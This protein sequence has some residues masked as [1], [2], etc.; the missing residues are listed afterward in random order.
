VLSPVHPDA[1]PA[2]RLNG[3]SQGPAVQAACVGSEGGGHASSTESYDILVIGSGE[4]GKYLA[5]TMAAQGHRTAVVERKLIGGSCPN[6]ACLPSKNIIHSAKVRS[7]T[8]RAAEF[9]VQLESA[10]TDMK[11]VQARKRAMVDGLRELHLDRFRASGAELIL[12]E[13]CF[14]GERTV[15]V[16]LADGGMRRIA[17][18]RLFLDLGTRA[19]LPEVPGLAAAR[20][21]TH[22]E[23]LDLDRLPEHLIVIG[24]G[25]VGLELAQAMRR[26]GAP[27]TLVEQGPQLA[28]HEDGDVGAALLELFHDEG[29][30]V[31][32]ET[33]IRSV[34]G[35]SGRQVRILVD[36]PGG[37]GAIEGTD[38][39]VGTG[40]TPNTRGIGLERAGVKLT[41]T[42]SIAVDERLATTAAGTWAMGDCAGSPQFTHAA[43]DDFRVVYDNLT[44]G[45]RTTRDRLVPYCMFTDPELARV[46]MNESDARR[47]GIGYRLLTLPMAAVLRTRTLSEPRGFMKMLIAADSDQILGFTVLGAEASE[48]MAAIQTAMIARLPYTALHRAIYAHPTAAEGLTF[49]LRGTPAAPAD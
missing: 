35:E 15:D 40:R 28:G 2:V 31:H 22:V 46:G 14:A 30:A 7:F 41:E 37:D 21:M 23:L 45:G 49:L 24:G 39:L 47:R 18:E 5:W 16:A 8:M 17:G 33:R 4:A 19:S 25:Y 12:G 10:V 1:S 48:M 11:G 34:Q 9:G 43:F 44:G 32:L 26:F 20:P 3:D 36:G 38:L 29:I 42:G 6:I 27:V 13:A